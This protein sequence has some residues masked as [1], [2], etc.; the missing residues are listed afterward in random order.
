V[1]DL[2]RVEDEKILRVFDIL[3][4]LGCYL[5]LM[6]AETRDFERLCLRP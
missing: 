3:A 2:K 1:V 4:G 6:K 5:Y